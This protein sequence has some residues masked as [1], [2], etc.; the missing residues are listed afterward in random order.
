MKR[1]GGE[2]SDVAGGSAGRRINGSGETS[3]RSIMTCGAGTGAGVGAVTGSTPF[4]MILQ[5]GLQPLLV[6]Q[7]SGDTEPKS[8]AQHAR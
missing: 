1:G 6:Q 2:Y 8:C 4:G 5:E 3:T 7:L